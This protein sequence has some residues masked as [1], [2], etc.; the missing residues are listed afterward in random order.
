MTDTN[1]E[2][3]KLLPVDNSDIPP[4]WSERYASH[5]MMTLRDGEHGNLYHCA[6]CLSDRF[7]FG[8]SPGQVFCYTCHAPMAD[9]VYS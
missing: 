2:D 6:A 7:L 3:L 1:N 9:P 5:Q 4:R 8:S